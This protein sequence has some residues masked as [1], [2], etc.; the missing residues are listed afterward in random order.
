[1]RRF[2]DYARTRQQRPE[3]D[4]TAHDI[5]DFLSHLAIRRH[6]SASTQNQ[7]MC[8]LLFLARHALGLDVDALSTAA[9]ARTP[10]RLPTVV[11][12]RQACVARLSR[13]I[14]RQR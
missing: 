11:S 10:R 12:F 7:A 13:S 4:V 1:M 14:T 9:R 3:P 5:R 2:Y 8:A 6:V